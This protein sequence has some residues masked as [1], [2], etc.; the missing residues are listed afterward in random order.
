[1]LVRDAK[2]LMETQEWRKV[3]KFG[4]ASDISGSSLF[5]KEYFASDLDQKGPVPS[6]LKTKIKATPLILYLSGPSDLLDQESDPSRFLQ[7]H[8]PCFNQGT[9][10]T[11]A[12]MS[13][14][15]PLNF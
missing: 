4:R 5:K 10:Y 15:N 13:T 11:I 1:M 3:R 2:L 12:L 14:P 8:F 9:D 7:I 6:A